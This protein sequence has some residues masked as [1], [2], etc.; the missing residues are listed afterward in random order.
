MVLTQEQKKV[1]NLAYYKSHISEFKIHNAN[2]R[3]KQ[4]QEIQA[5]IKRM[6][7]FDNASPEKQEEM[8]KACLEASDKRLKEIWDKIESKKKAQEQ[9][10]LQLKGG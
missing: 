2:Y 10:T 6:K 9:Q 5:L 4:K 8:K 7:A 1:Y 3:E